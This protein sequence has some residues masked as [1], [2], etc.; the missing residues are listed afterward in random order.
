MLRIVGCFS[1]V[2]TLPFHCFIISITIK[3]RNCL[4]H[5][6]VTCLEENKFQSSIL[7][8]NIPKAKFQLK[9]YKSPSTGLRLKALKLPTHFRISNVNDT[10]I[11]KYYMLYNFLGVNNGD[12]DFMTLTS[13]PVRRDDM[14]RTGYVVTRP[15]HILWSLQTGEKVREYFQ[16]CF[17]KLNFTSMVSR[18]EWERF[19]KAEGTRFPY[20]QYSNGVALSSL[21]K[22]SG[23]VLIGDALHSFP[24]DIGMGL[25]SGLQDVIALGEAL[26][27][28]NLSSPQCD[29]A[30]SDASTL[31]DALR[32]FE[33]DRLKEVRL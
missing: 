28:V 19:A 22:H 24:P 23:V 8:P 25:N 27:F 2:P 16:N 11:A 31:G 13:F 5:R 20:C 30:K 14:V 18:E 33:N 10:Y 32:K 4:R 1:L 7:W 12:N 21:D 15:N 26:K 17:P 9:R 3:V 6:N 29:E